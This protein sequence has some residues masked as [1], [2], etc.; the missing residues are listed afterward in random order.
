VG[1]VVGGVVGLLLVGGG[2][3]YLLGR[4]KRTGAYVAAGN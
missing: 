4:S 2:A 1:G 3:Y